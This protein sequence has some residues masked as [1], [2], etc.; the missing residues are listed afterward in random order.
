MEELLRAA[1]PSDEDMSD[2]I[3]WAL[4]EGQI[5]GVKADLAYAW[6]LRRSGHWEARNR[7]GG[8]GSQRERFC[9]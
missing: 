7:A 2:L 8:S 3:E 1:M 9:V 6:L 4:L 5:D